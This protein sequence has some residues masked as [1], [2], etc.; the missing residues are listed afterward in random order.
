MKHNA[1]VYGLKENDDFQ[2]L[3]RDFLRLEDYEKIHEMSR[4][5]E[6]GTSDFVKF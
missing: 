4:N 5:D 1:N 6:D 2:V 3:E